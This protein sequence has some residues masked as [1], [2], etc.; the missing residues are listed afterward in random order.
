MKLCLLIVFSLAIMRKNIYLIF[1]TNSFFKE[2]PLLVVDDNI[3]FKIV[4]YN[5]MIISGPETEL[6][7]F[8][9]E[10]AIPLNVLG[11]QLYMK[12]I[13][14]GILDKIKYKVFFDDVFDKNYENIE[15]ILKSLE[16]YEIK[17]KK[18][19]KTI[20]ISTQNDDNKKMIDIFEKNLSI[21]KAPDFPD[22]YMDF[23]SD[24]YQESSYT[25]SESDLSDNIDPE[26][27]KYY[28][29]DFNLFIQLCSK[30][31]NKE[32]D[33]T[34]EQDNILREIAEKT[35][36]SRYKENGE[37]TNFNHNILF[38]F[39][40][41]EYKKTNVLNQNEKNSLKVNENFYGVY[42]KE[43]KKFF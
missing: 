15:E 30:K 26:D 5:N 24:D 31:F 20:S 35:Y 14:Y 29:F 3:F 37:S 6:S 8:W 41:E 18:T 13:I 32:Y 16:P 38:D 11:T 4:E 34:K 19:N 27:P 23:D 17:N 25:E 42:E 7:P 10:I 1:G 21:N 39:I 12:K 33:L 28:F 9:R 2:S 40:L 36:K 43:E 22:V